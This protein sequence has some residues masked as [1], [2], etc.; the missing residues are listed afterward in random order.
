MSGLIQILA[1]CV[2]NQAKTCRVGAKA[3]WYHESY[4]EIWTKSNSQLHLGP[5]AFSRLINQI[6]HETC[7][8]KFYQTLQC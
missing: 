2:N 1:A 3:W 5:T 8:A 4:K 7:S 6:E